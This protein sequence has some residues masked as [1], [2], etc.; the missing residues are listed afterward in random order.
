M[1]PLTIPSPIYFIP[2]IGFALLLAMSRWIRAESRMP[3]VALVGL[4]FTC[5]IAALFVDEDSMPTFTLSHSGWSLAG[6]VA[7]IAICLGPAAFIRRPHLASLIRHPVIPSFLTVMAPLAWYAIL[8]Q[9]PYAVKALGVGAATTRSELYATGSL[10]GGPEGA[11]NTVAVGISHYYPVYSF[12][13]VIALI[14]REGVW[15]K[16]SMLIG[17]SLYVVN[18]LVFTAR[19]GVIW[20]ITSLCAAFWLFWPALP[21]RIRRGSLMLLTLVVAGAMT[22]LVTFTL[23]RFASA[24]N[25]DALRSVLGYFG[26]QPYVFA[27]TVVQQQEFY[28]FDLRFPLFVDFVRKPLQIKRTLPYEWSFGTF[29]R[30]Y[31]SV[32]GW[33]VGFGLSAFT[34]SAFALG[35]AVFRR[36]DSFS[37]SLIFALY[38]QFMVQGIFYFRLGNWSGNFYIVTI[39]IL[40]GT[41]ALIATR[42][43][44][45]TTKGLASS[46]A[47]EAGHLP[48]KDRPTT[49]AV[50]TRRFQVP[51]EKISPLT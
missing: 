51:S 6:Y 44:V 32:G 16:V 36:R 18:S 12:L 21:G 17:S 40:A 29:V 1:F 22:V 39:F 19:D 11:L 50:R 47:R 23:Q 43:A 10:A 27:E 14:R 9:L 24:G 41:V 35:M 37:Y 38:I 48:S 13:F 46:T 28:G 33:W 3:F 15:L 31:Y 30:D 7:M 4:Y 26:N 45:E 42:P 34:A 8:Y 25:I 2:A 49:Q 5:S 20:W